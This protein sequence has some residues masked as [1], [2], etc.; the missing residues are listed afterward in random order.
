MTRLFHIVA[1]QILYASVDTCCI[2]VIRGRQ[3]LPERAVLLRGPD[4]CH[5][6]PHELLA[7]GVLESQSGYESKSESR[8]NPDPNSNPD[9]DPS[10]TRMTCTCSVNLTLHS[11]KFTAVSYRAR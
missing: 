9:S 8:S 4:G 6:R 5:Q 10:P 1:S 2:P 7:E 11:M 3:V